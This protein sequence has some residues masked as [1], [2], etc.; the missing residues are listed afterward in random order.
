MKV[1]YFYKIVNLFVI[2]FTNNV[3]EITL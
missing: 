1:H 3:N 2:L